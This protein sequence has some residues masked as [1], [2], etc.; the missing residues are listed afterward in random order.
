VG[1]DAATWPEEILSEWRRADP[2]VPCNPG[3]RRGVR[4][5]TPPRRTTTVQIPMGARVVQAGGLLYKE[6]AISRPGR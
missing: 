5:P 3:A 6:K 2:L 1:M 4:A